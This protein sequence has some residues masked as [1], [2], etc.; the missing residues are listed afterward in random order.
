[1]PHSSIMRQGLMPVPPGAPSMVSRSILASA[2]HWIAMASSPHRVGAGLEGDPL[3]ARAC[4]AGRPRPGSPRG[5]TKPS[6]LC[7]SN[8]LDG[9]VLEGGLDDRAGRVGGDDVAAP[10]EFQGALE[11]VDLDLAADALGAL[12]PLELDGVQAVLVEDVLG[13]AQ[14]GVLDVHLHEDLAVAVV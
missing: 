14:A 8:S 3:E 7:R 13:D 6:R 1:M 4:G 10:L 11:D 9:A 2:D 5:S 12:A